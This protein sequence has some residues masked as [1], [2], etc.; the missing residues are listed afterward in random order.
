MDSLHKAKF[1][2]EGGAYFWAILLLLLK[3]GL[4]VSKLQWQIFFY[5]F[6]DVICLLWCLYLTNKICILLDLGILTTV[7]I[8]AA[9]ACM[10]IAYSW[11]SV[12]QSIISLV[13]MFNC[14]R[15]WLIIFSLPVLLN[16]AH[17]LYSW[18]WLLN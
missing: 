3:I 13:K 1:S 16:M 9:Y 5:G 7:S 11:N 6:C 12:V 15:L 2:D 18:F 14:I 4:G 8:K 17:C 10:A